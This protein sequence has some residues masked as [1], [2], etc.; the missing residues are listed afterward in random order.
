MPSDLVYHRL[1]CRANSQDCPA[2]CC[3]LRAITTNLSGDAK[4]AYLGTTDS[5]HPSVR[6]WL[7]H[8]RGVGGPCYVSR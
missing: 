6:K 8:C 3:Y 4:D 2:A 7:Q 1:R 5:L